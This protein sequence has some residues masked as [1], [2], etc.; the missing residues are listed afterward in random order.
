MLYSHVIIISRPPP[1]PR[2]WPPS[3]MWTRPPRATTARSGSPPAEGSAPTVADGR[4]G[5]LG[6]AREIP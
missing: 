1:D 6:L 3:C 4:S 5:P 2:T